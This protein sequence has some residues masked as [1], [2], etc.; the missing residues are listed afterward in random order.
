MKRRGKKIRESF[1]ISFLRYY[2]L[3]PALWNRNHDSFNDIEAK[4]KSYMLLLYKYK[5]T[6][7][8][9]TM[10]HMKIEI[11]CRRSTFLSY[12]LKESDQERP[13]FKEITFINC[14][15]TVKEELNVE[16]EYNKLAAKIDNLRLASEY[17]EAYDPEDEP[18]EQENTS[19]LVDSI[20]QQKSRVTKVEPQPCSSKEPSTIS[21]A[22]QVSVGT[23]T[24][25]QKSSVHQSTTRAAKNVDTKHKPASTVGVGTGQPVIK[26]P[27][28]PVI[29]KRIDC[30]AQSIEKT[31]VENTPI[32]GGNETPVVEESPTENAKRCHLAYYTYMAYVKNPGKQTK[33]SLARKLQT[34]QWKPVT[35]VP[36]TAAE[37]IYAPTPIKVTEDGDL[38]IPKDTKL[39]EPT[40]TSQDVS[41]TSR[42]K[43]RSN[44]ERNNDVTL[45]IDD[46]VLQDV[47]CG[48]DEQGTRVEEKQGQRSPERLIE[49]IPNVAVTEQF[50]TLNEIP[51]TQQ[52]NA[53]RNVLL[54]ADTV[55]M[56]NSPDI[57][58]L[59]NEDGV[60]RNILSQPHHVNFVVLDSS[61]EKQ[62][63]PGRESPRRT[64]LLKTFEKLTDPDTYCNINPTTTQPLYQQQY[65]DP[66]Y[67][68]ANQHHY[69]IPVSHPNQPYS[70]NSAI[71]QPSAESCYINSLFNQ[72]S[73][74]PISM[75]SPIPQ[76]SCQPLDI[77]MPTRQP[78][79]QPR[80]IDTPITQPSYQPHNI[81]T[82][83]PQPSYQPQNIDTPIPQPSHRPH[84]INTPIPQPS[85][86]PQN[87]NSPIP[88]PS[89]EPHNTYT[90]I[91]QPFYQPLDI[92]T[93]IRPPTIQLDNIDPT[94]NQPYIYYQQTDQGMA[95]NDRRWGQKVLHKIR[96]LNGW[97]KF[98]A[99]ITIDEILRQAEMGL[100]PN[101]EDTR[102]RSPPG[103]G[104]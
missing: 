30:K 76:P 98:F 94:I 64:K 44:Y 35:P 14:E 100:Q 70:M 58:F 43:K 77:N 51:R 50:E 42:D 97:Q 12:Y 60:T 26:R 68:P 32:S 8:E 23:R 15:E 37:R 74:Q 101:Q 72:Q 1:I 90:P 73:Y 16:E 65:L 86:Q 87:I 81:N 46:T 5:E 96:R 75:N 99:Q 7:P 69:V 6:F 20:L 29:E 3:L 4:K 28:T 91:R 83:I 41:G 67:Q 92:N 52:S 82:P 22:Q 88:Q 40:D 17:E 57:L 25:T 54:S 78:S 95:D 24:W 63:R 71:P 38:V 9:A 19:A 27:A 48:V 18:F 56:H 61:S 39:L 66:I 53:C 89:Y 103:S 47:E 21:R 79:Y 93:L 84:N 85:Y 31:S 49:G 33:T 59:S 55:Q 34:N 36:S 13:W 104:V 102:V 11:K 80:N 45:T 2:K 62:N 10:R